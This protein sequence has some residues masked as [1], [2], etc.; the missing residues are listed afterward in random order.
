MEQ[1]Y[2]K[3]L[4][5]TRNAW[6][7]NNCTGNT[8]SSFFASWPK[9]RIANAFFRAEKISNTICTD[10]YR[11]T[12]QEVLRHILNKNA[13]LGREFT[14][15]HAD[16][17]DIPEQNDNDIRRNAKL[18]SFFS[19]NRWNLAIWAR[20][21]LWAAGN[22]KNKSFD[23]FLERIQPD[24]IYMPCY[25]SAYMHRI[26]RHAAEKTG[27]RVVLFTGDD[28]YTFRQISFSPLFWINRFINRA[29]MRRSVRLAD[30]LFVV[31]E[32]QKEEYRKY[33]GDK[34]VL[35]HKGAEFNGFS[36]KEPSDPIK[37]V[38]TG[39]ISSGRWKTIA[40]LS[41]AIGEIN[42]GKTRVTLDVYSLSAR[43]EKMVRE[44][45]SGKGVS[46][47]PPASSAQIQSALKD[48]DLLL[49]V[50]PFGLRDSLKWRLSFST[51]LTDYLASSRAILAAG[52]EKL[53]SMSFLR[54]NDAAICV[55]DISQL[56]EKLGCIVD[57]PSCLLEYA[58]KAYLCGSEKCTAEVT[59]NTVY[60]YLSGENYD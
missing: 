19:R 11:V 41:R 22:R 5:L 31:S 55:N 47:M 59:Q 8:L 32:L 50:E 37:I 52:P 35:L 34:C 17:D 36:P 60:K 58:E 33:F 43:S 13:S 24:V 21:I 25:D 45:S 16:G 12:E 1:T 20:D 44:M 53:A 51:K 3:V 18:Y 42:R 7:N 15:S 49:F 30:T 29:V 40:A 27:A 26:L 54:E 6:N 2:P 57:D 9:E 14:Y 39:N 48:A 28:T 4:V 10:Y 56:G 23:S 38:Y 46:L